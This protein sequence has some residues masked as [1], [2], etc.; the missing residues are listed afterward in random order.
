MSKIRS[1]VIKVP[2]IQVV[3]S[4]TSAS[5]YW[6]YAN[7]FRGY[8]G[9]K[10]VRIYFTLVFYCSANSFLLL[11][12]IG[13]NRK[14]TTKLNCTSLR[15][16]SSLDS[17]DDNSRYYFSGYNSHYCNHLNIIQDMDIHQLIVTCICQLILTTPMVNQPFHH[18]R[19]ILKLVS[20]LCYL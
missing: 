9:I 5:A 12:Y 11:Q 8:L 10:I 13:T 15:N 17:I 16:N 14:K 19:N 4:T 7:R 18:L 1:I 2:T 20:Y 3:K 6:V